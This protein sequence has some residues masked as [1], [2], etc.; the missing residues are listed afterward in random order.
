MGEQLNY[1]NK[2]NTWKVNRCIL[3]CSG[4]FCKN[5]TKKDVVECITLE[6]SSVKEELTFNYKSDNNSIY[7]KNVKEIYLF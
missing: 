2:C 3:R 5:K 4:I 7:K 6:E 1:S